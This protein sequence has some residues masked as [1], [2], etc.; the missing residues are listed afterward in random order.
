MGVMS[1]RRPT[2]RSELVFLGLAWGCP[3]SQGRLVW[4]PPTVEEAYTTLG[5]PADHDLGQLH[6]CG[7]RN[8]GLATAPLLPLGCSPPNPSI[9]EEEQGSE[10]GRINF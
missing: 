5:W 10:D 7:L 6:L 8:P 3:M 2:Q 1:P 9:W 4:S